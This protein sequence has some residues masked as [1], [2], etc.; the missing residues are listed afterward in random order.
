[1]SI[2]RALTATRIMPPNM[3]HST[4]KILLCNVRARSRTIYDLSLPH[5]TS[6][7]KR[8]L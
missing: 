7:R 1:M 5:I 4:T 6:Q 2:I 8:A 3:L